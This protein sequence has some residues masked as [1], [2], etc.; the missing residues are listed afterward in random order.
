MA[1][2]TPRDLL[3]VLCR[4]CFAPEVGK[5]AEYPLNF[6][7]KTYIFEYLNSRTKLVPVHAEIQAFSRRGKWASR[8]NGF[9]AKCEYSYAGS[10][11]ASTQSGGG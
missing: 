7:T 6:N 1:S 5:A 4:D 10:T 11:R 3:L 9:V 2:L 8:D